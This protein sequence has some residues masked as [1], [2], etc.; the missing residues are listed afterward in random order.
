[1]K[2]QWCGLDWASRT[3]AVCVVD[4][5]GSIR[6]RFEVPN[7]GKSFAGLVKRL[8]KLRVAG[9]A[10][11]RPDG[12]LVEALLEAGL[13]VHVVP[14]SMLKAVRGRYGAAGA[15]SDPGDAFVL[16]DLLRTDHH[17]L[18][19]LVPDGSA[20]KGLRALTRARKD[21][22][23]ARVGLTNQLL[24]QLHVC[25]PGAI[26]LF[27]DLHSV[28]A[29]AF[30]R[31]YPTAAR[32]A[33]LTEAR[34][35]AFLRRIHYCGRTPV[36]E[37]LRRLEEAPPAVLGSEEDEARA[38]CV[39]GLVE[40]IQVCQARARDLEAEIVE[41][42]EVHP[43]AHVFTS[44]PRAGR[45]VRAASLLAEI[46]DA[47]QRFPDPQ[48]L[49]ALAGA[50]PVTKASGK[51]RV[52]SFRWA[53]DKKLRAAVIDFADD[54]RHASAW[55][56]RIYERSIAKGHTHPHA[57]RI[58]ARAWLRVIWRCW[59]DGAAYDVAKHRGAV[60]PIAA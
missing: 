4:D 50:A 40:A 30:L 52:V 17:R 21:L 1:V 46:G 14:P 37:L 38:A 5:D 48:S 8:V 59:Q 60:M 13:T 26:G 33:S 49:M 31:R 43:D 39:L 19:P 18:T 45:G 23:E 28:V 16:A 9:V 24:A 20:T 56:E 51:H 22:I 32:A 57:I 55:A 58:L 2:Q 25:F 27:A 53:C 42:L 15:K 36:A 41:R 6:A 34:L 12:P 11:E 47:R 54:S 3:H 10:I 7:T 35:A 44:L 29:A